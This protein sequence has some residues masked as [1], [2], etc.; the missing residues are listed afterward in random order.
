MRV[1]NTAYAAIHTRTRHVRHNSRN[2][3]GNFAKLHGE[4]EAAAA[5]LAFPAAAAT[6]LVQWIIILDG[7][8]LDVHGR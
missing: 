1:A 6:G 5:D 4:V 2:E 3:L 8:M 7:F